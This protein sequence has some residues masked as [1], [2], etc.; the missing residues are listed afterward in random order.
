MA[1]RIKPEKPKKKQ[2]FFEVK[3][4]KIFSDRN[5]SYSYIPGFTFGF[6]RGAPKILL[7]TITLLMA[8]NIDTILIPIAFPVPMSI[9]I[10]VIGIVTIAW[11]IT[12]GL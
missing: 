3:N 7:G 2:F 9:I 12:E 4:K 5:S 6:L 1:E 10:A 8:S 11:G